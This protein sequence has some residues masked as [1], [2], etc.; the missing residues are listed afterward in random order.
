MRSDKAIKK[1]TINR[2]NIA[3][4]ADKNPILV[5]ALDPLIGN[6]LGPKIAKTEYAEGHSLNEAALEITDLSE[7]EL[8]SSL[9]PPKMTGGRT[10]KR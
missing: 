8:K 9:N 10:H 2:E 5:T 6:E 7:G 4:L 3:V 1:F